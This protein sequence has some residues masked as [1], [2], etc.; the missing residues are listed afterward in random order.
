[1]PRI[2]TAWARVLLFL[3]AGA[4]FYAGLVAGLTFDPLLGTVLW[5]AAAAIAAFTLWWTR[6]RDG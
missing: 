2:P 6:R 1:M 4:V 5:G 3:L